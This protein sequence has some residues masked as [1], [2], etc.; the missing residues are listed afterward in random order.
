MKDIVPFAHT[1]S[2]KRL[3]HF[4]MAGNCPVRDSVRDVCLLHDQ[5][6]KDTNDD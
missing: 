1:H 6:L 2:E 3:L 5:S 4:V